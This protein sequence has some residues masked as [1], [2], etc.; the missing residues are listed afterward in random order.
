[1]NVYQAPTS[2]STASGAGTTTIGS[3]AWTPLGCYSDSSSARVL[4]YA[5]A[6]SS[7]NSVNSC[8]ST[9][10]GKG[11]V[12]GGVEYGKQCFCGSSLASGAKSADSSD[13]NYTCASGSGICG[14]FNYINVYNA[15]SGLGDDCGLIQDFGFFNSGRL[16]LWPSTFDTLFCFL[17]NILE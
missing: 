6:E 17:W 7:I 5:A 1:M 16:F 3:V 2:T 11:Y 12:Y 14:G 10:A 15:A 13:C 8:L 4:S 9:C